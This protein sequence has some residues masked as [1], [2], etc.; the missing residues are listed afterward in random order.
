MERISLGGGPVTEGFLDFSFGEVKIRLSPGADMGILDCCGMGLSPPLMDWFAAWFE[1]STPPGTHICKTDFAVSLRVLTNHS[2][3]LN[4]LRGFYEDNT[5]IANFKGKLLFIPVFDCRHWSLAVISNE[6]FFKFDSGYHSNPNFHGPQR[7]HEAMAKIWCMA[8]GHGP[9]TPEWKRAASI[10]S[11]VHAS[12][13]Q[14]PDDWTCGFY[15]ACY[16]V[17]LCSYLK[18]TTANERDW[19]E[20]VS[21]LLIELFD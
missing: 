15:V 7:L 6:G 13:P 21:I 1:S 4:A 11:W 9:G 14:Q 12:C 5:Y 16:I 10:R 2:S 19:V 17:L 18:Q 3:S 8:N 20:G